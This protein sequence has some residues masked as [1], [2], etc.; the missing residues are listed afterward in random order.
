MSTYCVPVS[1]PDTWDLD[2]GSGLKDYTVQ[3]RKLVFRT[4]GAHSSHLEG[5]AGDG[6]W[7]VRH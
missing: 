7:V 4:Q 1:V 2:V 3:T 6:V 5:G